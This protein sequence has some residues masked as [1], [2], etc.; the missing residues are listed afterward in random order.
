MT[1]FATVEWSLLSLSQGIRSLIRGMQQRRRTAPKNMD[2]KANAG[3]WI[4]KIGELGCRR[5]HGP[6]PSVSL[7]VP[8]MCNRN[9]E[10]LL[11]GQLTPARLMTQSRTSMP[12]AKRLTKTRA[13]D[14]AKTEHAR[15]WWVTLCC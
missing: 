12:R 4:I 3:G 8:T 15:W 13:H 5:G 2:Q 1:Q 9:D 6:I 11:S 14:G 7:A 10:P